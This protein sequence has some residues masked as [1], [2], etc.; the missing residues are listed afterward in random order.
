MAF[1]SQMDNAV[2]VIFLHEVEHPVKVTDI[3]FDE[4][5]VR[6]ILHIG[7]ILEITGIGQLIHIDD[8]VIGILVHKKSYHMA[9]DETG[10]TGYDDS[11]FHLRFLIH[12]LNDS[13]Q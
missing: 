6:H 12:F 2:N 7:K 5:V 8:M 4:C 10:A 13:V 3:S 11:A 1:S 9:T